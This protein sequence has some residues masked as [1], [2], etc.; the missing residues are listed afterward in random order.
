MKQLIERVAAQAVADASRRETDWRCAGADERGA[1]AHQSAQDGQDATTGGQRALVLVVGAGSGADLASWRALKP[2]RLLLLEPQS[3]MTRTL[4]SRLRPSASEALLEAALVTTD[5]PTA[6]LHVLS[7]PR[8]SALSQPTGLLEHFPN[9][10]L[11]QIQDVPTVRLGQIL[12]ALGSDALSLDA[13]PDAAELPWP[14][15]AVLIVEAPG[16]AACLASDLPHLLARFEWVVVRCGEQALFE[17]DDDA[18]ALRAALEPIGFTRVHASDDAIPP[19]VEW[20]FQRQPMAPSVWQ[21]HARLADVA[22]Q[23]DRLTQER[24]AQAARSEALQA[25]NQALTLARDAGLA[26]QAELV[27]ERDALAVQFANVTTAREAL[28]QEKAELT[29]QRD[30]LAKEKAELVAARDGQAKLAAE[31]Q[32]QVESLGRE[33]AELTA[34]RDGLA[35]DKSS[36]QAQLDEARQ[37][38]ETGRQQQ[39]ELTTR[40]QLMQEELVK[41]EAQIELIKD[42]LLREPSL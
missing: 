14:E 22:A 4:S 16:V 10:K 34:A 8:E 36:L 2:R 27:A 25:E 18:T 20:L 5:E 13:Q 6:P 17:G 38:L 31:R 37:Q 29:G 24:V 11:R 23:C 32:A 39:Q 40:Q 19:Y 1:A 35:K 3:S 15:G 41:A 42:L 21:T 28:A 30:A 26:T 7:N 33:K 9:L 12:G